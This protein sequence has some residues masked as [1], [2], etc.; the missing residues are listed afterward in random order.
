MGSVKV[1]ILGAGGFVRDAYLGPLRVRAP[2]LCLAR[3]RRRRDEP[4]PACC[5][6]ANTDKLLP[7][8]VWSRSSDSAA[9]LLPDIQA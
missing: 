8:A 6:Q 4:G 1:A 2:P 7:A 9:K 5:V 3:C